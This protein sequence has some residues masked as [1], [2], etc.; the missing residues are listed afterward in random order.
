MRSKIVSIL[1]TII[2]AYEAGKKIETLEKWKLRQRK[3]DGFKPG[4]F[5]QHQYKGITPNQQNGFGSLWQKINKGKKENVNKANIYDKSL[6][7]KSMKRWKRARFLKQRNIHR[8]MRNKNQQNRKRFQSWLKRQ[9]MKTKQK[10]VLARRMRKL[11][12]KIL[13]Q[14]MEKHLYH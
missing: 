7:K 2:I 13:R 1:A 10:L 11:W 6:P 9:N 4:T 8:M 14:C 5:V 3:L 12:T